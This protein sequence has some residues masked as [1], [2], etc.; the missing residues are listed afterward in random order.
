MALLLSLN[1]QHTMAAM[2]G[3]SS[4]LGPDLGPGEWMQFYRNTFPDGPMIAPPRGLSMLGQIPAVSEAT[5]VTTVAST[6]VLGP[7]PTG[8]PGTSI[9]A[10]LPE[11]VLA[12]R[13]ATRKRGRALRRAPTTVLN[14][15]L[16]NFRAMVQQFT[17]APTTPFSSMLGRPDGRTVNSGFERPG[18]LEA[19]M[20]RPSE[21]QHHQQYHHQQQQQQNF[22]QLRQG[23]EEMF[24]MGRTDDDFFSG[25]NNPRS[26]MEVTEEYLVSMSSQNGHTG[27]GG[28]YMF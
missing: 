2:N 27:S 24:S 16:T 23:E 25:L 4:D 12:E 26:N 9:G 28:G 8:G 11:D 1:T 15:D 18:G 13:P 14:T 22:Q 10:H 17:G 20:V 7:L 5:V 19:M 3:T 21:T 6:I